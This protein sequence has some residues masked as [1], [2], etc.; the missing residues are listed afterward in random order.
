VLGE[1]KVFRT[2]GEQ[3]YDYLFHQFKQRSLAPGSFLDLNEI[4]AKLGISRTPL[5]DALFALEVE[6][7]VEI[8]PRRGV[9]VKYLE[10]EDIRHIYQVIGTLEATA[11][12]EAARTL[13][14]EDHAHLADITGQ[15]RQQLE[16]GSFDGCLAINYEFHDFFLGRCGNDVLTRMVRTQKQRLYDWPRHTELLWEWER[17][18]VEVHEQM[19]ERLRAG[20]PDGAAVVMQDSHWGFVPQEHFIR[21]FYEGSPAPER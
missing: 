5:R 17:H 14:P 10:I 12:R 18:C 16:L 3:V 19:V 11:L 4:A 6:G 21:S 8:V 1:R 15:Y 2:L 7:Y 9:K 20:D 13:A